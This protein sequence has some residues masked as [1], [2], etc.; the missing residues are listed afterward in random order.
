M[1]LAVTDSQSYSS[2]FSIDS[3]TGLIKTAKELDRE[4]SNDE[5]VLTVV[6]S[7]SGSSTVT[8]T[9]TVTINDLNDNKPE[10]SPNTYYANVN[11]N[12]A[13]GKQFFQLIHLDLKFSCLPSMYICWC[14]MLQ[15]QL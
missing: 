13:S 9:M 12:S 3:L 1:F 7:D 2:S 14:Y 8:G 10:C 15:V 11:E 5:Y 4:G 6:A